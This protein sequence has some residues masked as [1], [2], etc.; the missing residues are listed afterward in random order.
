[1]APIA[2]VLLTTILL[3]APCAAGILAA[4]APVWS[5][6]L[7]TGCIGVAT[8]GVVLRRQPRGDDDGHDYLR[9]RCP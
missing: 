1:M 9:R 2:A 6:L 7:L 5:A 4:G 3:G 8:A